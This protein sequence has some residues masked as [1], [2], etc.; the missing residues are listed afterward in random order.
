MRG[1]A[2]RERRPHPRT[3]PHP[4]LRGTFPP[5]GGRFCGRQDALPPRVILSAAKDPFPLS[6][7]RHFSRGRRSA[8]RRNKKGRH[9]PKADVFLGERERP[10]TKSKPSDAGSIWKGGAAAGELADRP[11]GRR[12]VCA[13]R[14]FCRRQNLG[15]GGIHFRRACAVPKGGAALWAAEP[16]KKDICESRCLSFWYA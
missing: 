5:E 16:K 2:A 15:A 3:P 8:A 9:P 13:V 4:P 11:S 1:P 12:R 7:P 6:P 14:A 10:K